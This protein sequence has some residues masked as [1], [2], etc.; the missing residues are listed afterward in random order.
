[1]VSRLRT[2]IQLSDTPIYILPPFRTWQLPAPEECLL[3][4]AEKRKRFWA[5]GRTRSFRGLRSR[6]GTRSCSAAV[7][8]RTLRSTRAVSYAFEPN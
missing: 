5:K 1:M 8:R 2:A 6:P 7:A 4:R 3:V